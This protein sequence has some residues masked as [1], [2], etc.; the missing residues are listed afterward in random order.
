MTDHGFRVPLVIRGEVI[1]EDAVSHGGRGGGISFTAP[2]VAAYLGKLAL[3]TPSSMSDLYALRMEE[4]FEFLSELGHRLPP[5]RNPW[6][7]EAF[8]I[9]CHTSGLGADILRA[10]YEN[11]DRM[12]DPGSLREAAENSIGIDYLENWVEMPLEGPVT[13]RPRLR[14]ARGPYCGGQRAGHLASDRRPQRHHAERRDHQDAE[15]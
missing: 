3:S 2:D 15:Q 12:L 7:E 14:R 8:R 11:M 4:I 10:M 6:M 13:A 1:E 5:S 9:S